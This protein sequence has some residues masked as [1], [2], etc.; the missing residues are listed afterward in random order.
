MCF[1]LLVVDVKGL[2]SLWLILFSVI[3]TYMFH[4]LFLVGQYFLACFLLFL[5]FDSIFITY[6]FNIIILKILQ[7][8][9]LPIGLIF[10]FS[11]AVII[12]GYLLWLSFLYSS[13][14]FHRLF[15][16]IFF[17]LLL[18]NDIFYRLFIE[19][20]SFLFGQHFSSRGH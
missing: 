8:F 16:T 7:H 11:W 6:S 13:G 1:V 15:I 10:F 18:G 4:F 17:S 12:I 9:S 20:I 3:I 5:Y 2:V 14:N 19:S